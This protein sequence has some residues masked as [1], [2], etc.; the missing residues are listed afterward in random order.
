MRFL[1]Q[2][3]GAV[4]LRIGLARATAL[5]YRLISHIA[6]PATMTPPTKSTKQ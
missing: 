2:L 5:T 1:D 3:S 6:Q 4:V